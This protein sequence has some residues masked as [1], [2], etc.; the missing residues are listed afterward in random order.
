MRERGSASIY[1]VTIL[2]LLMFMMLVGVH[3]STLV[4]DTH[5][6]ARAADLAA[7]AATEAAIAGQDGCLLARRVARANDARVI[8][9][10]MRFEVATVTAR[11]TSAPIWGK[12]FQFDRRARAAPADLVD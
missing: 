8:A 4:R 9:C 1:S 3:L 10:S 7:I 6:A 2:A 12:R 11:V 5:E